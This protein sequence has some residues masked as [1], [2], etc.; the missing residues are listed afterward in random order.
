MMRQSDAGV[1]RR[2]LLLL[3]PLVLAVAA[4]QAEPLPGGTLDP[5]TIPKY[6]TPLVIPPVMDTTGTPNDFDI[7]VRQFQQ[8]ILPGGIWNTLNGRTDPFPATKVWSYGPAADPTPSV[9]PDPA[10]QFNYPAYT[11]EAIKNVTTTVDWFNELVVDPVACKQSATPATDPACNFL[12]HILPV[13]RSLHWANP[14]GLPCIEPNRVK[15]CA[16]DPAVSGTLLQQ[17][18]DGPVPMVPHLHGSHA[19]PESDGYAEAWWLPAANNIDCRDAPTY[20][21]TQDQTDDYWCNGTLVNQFGVKTNAT[22]G[23]A[24]F[25]YFNDQ[26]A[27]TFWYHDHSLGMTRNNV[28]A[29]PAGFYI[30]RDTAALGGETGLVS[31]TLP[32]PAPIAGQAVLDLNV[33]GNP[34]RAAVREIPIVIQDRSFNADGSLFYPDNRAF[35]EGLTPDLLQIPFIGDAI[36]SDIAPIWNPEAFFN[37]MVVNGVSWPSLEVE[38]DLYRFRLLNGCNSRFINLAL[39]VVTGPGTDGIFGTADDALGAELPF[40]QIGAEQSLL[41]KVVEV[42]TG[43]KTPLPGDGTVPAAVPVAAA[44]E[45]LLMGSAERADVI[46]DFSGLAPGT[47]V[48]MIN[49]GP[50]EPFGGFPVGLPPDPDTTFQVMEFMVGTDDP[51]VGEGFTPPASLVLSPVENVNTYPAGRPNVLAQPR[52]QALLEEESILICVTVDAVSGAL[53]YDPDAVPNPADP[54]T[55]ILNDGTGAVAASLPFGPKAAVLGINGSSPNPTITLWSDPI[56][57]NPRFDAAGNPPTETWEF[58]NHTVDAHPIHVHETKYKVLNREAF[59][60]ASGALVPGTLRSPEATEAGWKDTVIAYPG[61]VTRI[62]ATFDLQGLY[63]WHCHIVEHEDNEMMVPYCIGN[64]DPALGPV[65]PGCILNEPP[66]V[67]D[68]SYS[69][70]EDTALTV[71]APGVLANDTDINANNVVT[72]ILVSGPANGTLSLNPGGSFTYTP[73]LNFN[74]TDSFTYKANDGVLDSVRAAT[75]TITVTPVLVDMQLKKLK[76]P[77]KATSREKYDVSVT[78]ANIGAVKTSGTVTLKANGSIVR[79]FNYNLAPKAQRT[80]TFKWTAPVVTKPLTVNWEATVAA[81]GDNNPVNNTATAS[82]IVNPKK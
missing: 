63:V 66:V 43:F 4:A 78:I 21:A 48:R 28:Y 9:A 19:T 30:L 27:A 31:G 68:D 7:A 64:K 10:S 1:A 2:R 38:Q 3:T 77:N 18:Y 70:K 75:V 71:P 6:V 47:R 69:T 58:W 82:T 35:F 40:Y 50:D 12:P 20:P 34:V 44:E 81:T 33:P 79:T 26:P 80:L 54:E 74:G 56:A 57:V 76:V 46:V 59:D 32:G 62:V 49:T 14:E 67:A 15:D 52:D 45:A 51:T 16:P 61:E 5:L 36:S 8:Q 73:N 55:C 41:P 65:A 72:A 25:K 39:F 22:P 11:V 17:P 42:K 37:T 23:A 13:D 29:G 53:V 24:S 60:P